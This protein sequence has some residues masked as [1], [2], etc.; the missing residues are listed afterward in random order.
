MWIPNNNF[1][2]SNQK[3]G[4][5]NIKCNILWLTKY[6]Q[7]TYSKIE[8]SVFCKVCVYSKPNNGCL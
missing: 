3:I 6:K 7:L 5:Q 8:D 4:N 2:I 1:N